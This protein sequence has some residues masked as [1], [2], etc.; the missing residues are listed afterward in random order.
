LRFIAAKQNEKTD[1]RNSREMKKW[2]LCLL[3]LLLVLSAGAPAFAETTLYSAYFSCDDDGLPEYWLDF[4][5]SVADNLVLHCYSLTDSWYETWYILDFNSAVANSHQGAYRIENIYDSQGFDVSNRFKTVSLAINEGS[6]SLY[7]ERNPEAPSGGPEDGLY[8]M[9]PANA[10]VV[11]E[12]REGESLKNW[13]VLNTGV[14][15]LYFSD[16]SVWYLEPEDTEGDN[17]VGVKRIVSRTGEAVPFQSFTISYVQG[18][19]LLD[20]DAGTS[21]SGSFLFTPRVV[22]Q[23]S[24]CSEREL[25]RMAQMYYFRHNGFYP[26]EADVEANGDGTFSVH[27]Y[28][29]VN[30]GDGTYHTATSAWYTV[31]ASGAGADDI[32]G[33]PVNLQF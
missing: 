17:T 9:L 11:Y 22:L 8:E 30:N 25:A 23:R 32:F 26:P 2:L 3:A 28:E 15:E 18:S 7:I 1:E 14:A 19:M 16:G 10:G 13:L 4:T 6:V 27:L 24:D 31:D 20:A 33:T 12:Y 21:F 5:G 29:I